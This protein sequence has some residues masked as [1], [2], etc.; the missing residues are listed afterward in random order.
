M[1]YFL[2]SSVT[3]LQV[4]IP[5]ARYAFE[6]HEIQSTFVMTTNL[7]EYACPYSKSNR[8]II[9]K[10]IKHLP[11]IKLVDS[12][13]EILNTKAVYFIVDGDIYGQRKQ[14]VKA[15]QISKLHKDSYIVSLQE[16][17]N[18]VWAY[19]KFIENVSVCVFPNEHLAKYYKKLSS[20]NV[21]LGNPKFDDI[22]T[23]KQSIYNKYS[24]DPDN[25]YC[26]FLYP[27]E[28]FMNKLK[29]TFEKTK[30][31]IDIIENTLG[32]TVIVKYRPKDADGNDL[33]KYKCVVS[34]C[35]PNQSIE[36]MTIC[37]LCVMF[38]SSC[39]DE[40]IITNTPCM[41]CIIDYDDCKKME[42]LH[43]E[44]TLQKIPQWEQ[45][46]AKQILK[47]YNRLDK[48]DSDIY[49][50]LRKEYLFDLNS[51]SSRIVNHVIDNFS[52]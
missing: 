49:E 34:D 3:F 21:Y 11:F 31:L 22:P 5:I 8:K 37:D 2:L 35:Y 19:D 20:K 10:T 13:P 26:I 52:C 39:I 45:K 4:Y 44:R 18:F 25:K 23:N 27:R 32:L 48:P 51:S 16:H 36:L 41:D 33:S 29:I 14:F 38:S 6:K 47:I 30:N 28:L 50:T 17:M 40:C 43:N 9:N 15:S 42:Y 24:L 7:K 12:T 1:F 46:N